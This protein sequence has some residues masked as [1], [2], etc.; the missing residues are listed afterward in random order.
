[1]PKI[2]ADVEN[3]IY[4]AALELFTS[5]DYNSVNMKKVARNAGIA[6]G[7]LYN[8][9]DNKEELF[10]NV[11]EKSWQTTFFKLDKIARELEGER[12]FRET[13]SQLYDDISQRKGMGEDLM[14]G[15]ILDAR[16]MKVINQVKN[17]IIKRLRSSLEECCHQRGLKMREDHKQR[18]LHMLLVEIIELVREFP[19]EREQNLCFLKQ[20]L[21]TLTEK[22]SSDPDLN[23]LNED[24]ASSS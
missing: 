7:T 15:N 14:E 1:M 22:F 23:N 6:V 3:K 13:I 5:T 2:I 16:G 19:E 17:K 18:L 9:Y 8:Y 24:P 21:V 10:L 11:L 12:Q 4:R 20:M